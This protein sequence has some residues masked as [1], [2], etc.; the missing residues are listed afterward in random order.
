MRAGLQQVRGKTVPQGVRANGLGEFRGL[1]C[2]ADRLRY[3][4][5]VDMV[6]PD[7]PGARIRPGL[8]GWECELPAELFHRSWILPLKRMR[9]VGI[10]KPGGKVAGMDAL[11]VLKVVA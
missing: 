10:A 7:N 9:H 3:S 4:R 1:P 6:A 8:R 11:H 2:R 5:V